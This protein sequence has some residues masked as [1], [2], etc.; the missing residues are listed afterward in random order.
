MKPAR[1]ILIVAIVLT[2]AQAARA[3]L[4]INVTERGPAV[5]WSARA[6][7]ANAPADQAAVHGGVA[8]TFLAASHTVADFDL[9]LTGA[10][11]LLPRSAGAD[12]QV[13]ELPA[14][15]G[16]A[17]LFLSAMLSMGGWHVLRSA[18]HI[19]L[20]AIP[21]WYHAGGP[22]QVGHAVP[23]DLDFSASPLCCFEQP[24]GERPY[25]Y[26]VRREQT[27]PR[28]DAQGFLLIA[29]PRGPPTLS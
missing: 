4:C 5:S 21:E 23:F 7:P 15:P 9:L 13:R 26:R 2:A 27:R 14:L 24:V 12:A 10:E 1:A 17:Q 25:L 20:G 19:H 6:L 28:C 16:S 8:T 3:D 22:A 11:P 18:R 29:A